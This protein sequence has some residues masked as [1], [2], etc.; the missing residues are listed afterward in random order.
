MP[1]LGTLRSPV[2]RTQG[3][4]CLLSGCRDVRASKWDRRM[5]ACERITL[6]NRNA[7]DY[8]LHAICYVG[9]ATRGPA[10]TP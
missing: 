1:R 4:G 10:R 7:S 5:H 2:C 6:N 8:A 3:E 9:D